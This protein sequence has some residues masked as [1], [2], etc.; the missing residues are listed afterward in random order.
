MILQTPQ[1]QLQHQRYSIATGT[2]KRY[3]RPLRGYA[4]IKIW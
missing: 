4:Y 3:I 1:Q 2:E